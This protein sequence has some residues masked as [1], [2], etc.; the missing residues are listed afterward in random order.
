MILSLS[1]LVEPTLEM[2]V[3]LAFA[4][5]FVGLAGQSTELDSSKRKPESA[6]FDT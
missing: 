3:G 4:V 5:V 1:F 6:L 2:P